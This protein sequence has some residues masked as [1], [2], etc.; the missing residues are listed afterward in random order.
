MRIE[1]NGEPREVAEAM[2]LLDLIEHLGLDARKIA[3]E[4]NLEIVPRSAYP[5]IQLGDGDSLEIVHFIGGGSEAAEATSDDDALIV[6]GRRYA[7]RLIVGTGK[8]KDFEQTRDAV[9]AAGA[10]IVTV[11]VRRVNIAEPGHAHADRLPRSQTLHVPAQHGRLLL[12]GRGPSHITPRSRGGGAG[13]WSSSRCWVTSGRCSPIWWRTAGRRRAPD[14][15]RLRGH[16]LLHRRSDHGQAARGARLL[17]HHAARRA[18]RLG[19]SASRTRSIS[20]SS[21]SRPKCR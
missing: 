21:S 6:A 11:A 7:S 17:R 9:E 13:T 3:L 8:Y 12:R 5:E 19:A 18:D 2:T 4:R 10:E 16:G 1:I 14:R 20:A 15:G